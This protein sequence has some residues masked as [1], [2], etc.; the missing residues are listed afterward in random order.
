MQLDGLQK[1]H[2]ARL[3]QLLHDRV[4]KLV[5]DRTGL[6]AQIKGTMPNGILG[7]DFAINFLKARS[8]LS[9]P[10]STGYNVIHIL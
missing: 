1:G 5:A 4:Q 10:W 7:R 2:V 8:L 9:T 3:W 6:F